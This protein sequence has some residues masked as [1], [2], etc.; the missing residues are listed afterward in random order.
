MTLVPL[1]ILAVLAGALLAARA[2]NRL[3]L[4]RP[5]C[6]AVARCLAGGLLMGTGAALVPGGN[7]ALV[8]H[9]AP[10]LALHAA[11]AYAAL[12]TGVGGTLLRARAL[13]GTRRRA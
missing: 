1:L 6:A 2:R 8:L 13:S 11:L 5:T 10:G 4:R 3:R 9:A 7:D 12:V